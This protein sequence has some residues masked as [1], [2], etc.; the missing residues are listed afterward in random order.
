MAVEFLVACL[1]H[2]RQHDQNT[3]LA[4]RPLWAV[5]PP[6]CSSRQSASELTD[7]LLDD[8]IRSA[9]RGKVRDIGWQAFVEGGLEEMDRLANQ[10]DAV[11]NGS[12]ET[13]TLDKW[14]DGIGDDRTQ[15][16]A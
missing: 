2:Y 1:Q 12:F 8:P 7:I 14:W 13:S 9:L 3:A 5:S 16:T 10:V 4:P 6:N 11:A 15:W